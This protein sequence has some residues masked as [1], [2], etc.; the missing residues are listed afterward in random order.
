M[1]ETSKI[2]PINFYKWRTLIF[3]IHSDKSLITLPHHRSIMNFEDSNGYKSM[4]LEVG[5]FVGGEKINCFLLVLLR[6][7]VNAK[8]VFKTFGSNEAQENSQ[9]NEKRFFKT[10]HTI[11]HSL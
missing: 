3:P 11:L 10:V 7:S 2:S 4:K 1:S 9:W 5:E 6:W 8:V